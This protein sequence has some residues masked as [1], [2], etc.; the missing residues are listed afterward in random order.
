MPTYIILSKQ[1]RLKL[2]YAGIYNTVYNI[3]NTNNYIDFSVG[4]STYAAQL[5][6]G[7][8]SATTLASS[9]VTAMT[10]QVNNTWAITYSAITEMF[11]VTGAANFQLL[12]SSGSHASNSLYLVMGY[13]TPNGLS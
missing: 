7:I 2:L 12:F 5:S 10:A 13:C 4:A 9:L 6:P 8:Y 3:D 1:R 11:T